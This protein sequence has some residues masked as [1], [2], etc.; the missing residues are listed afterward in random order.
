ML[1]LSSIHARTRGEFPVGAEDFL[2]QLDQADPDVGL[3]FVFADWLEEHE[4]PGC[5]R[6]RACADKFSAR[7]SQ[8]W[9]DREAEEI[10]EQTH[11]PLSQVYSI[12][13]RC[14]F[15][16]ALIR[17]VCELADAY[18]CSATEAAGAVRLS[19]RTEDWARRRKIPPEKVHE[20]RLLLASARR[21]YS[22]R[23]TTRSAPRN[24]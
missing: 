9:F 10:A 22:E 20:I 16:T 21:E 8:L 18:D 15:N 13:E 24:K 5:E 19:G 17:A 14:Y 6:I 3:L 12:R 4:H 1:W 11:I 23:K 2:D 7:M